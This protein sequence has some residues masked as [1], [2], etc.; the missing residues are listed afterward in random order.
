[1][2]F[3]FELI[4]FAVGDTSF[5]NAGAGKEMERLLFEKS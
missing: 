5:H 2:D 1:M 4:P 3:L